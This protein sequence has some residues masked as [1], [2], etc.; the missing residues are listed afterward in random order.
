MKK[1]I[2]REEFVKVIADIYEFNKRFNN[3]NNGFGE[4]VTLGKLLFGNDIINDISAELNA[5][6]I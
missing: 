3:E 6:G 4:Q 5:R 1:S 2:S